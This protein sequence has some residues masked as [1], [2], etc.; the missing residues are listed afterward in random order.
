MP[1]IFRGSAMSSSASPSRQQWKI[2]VSAAIAW[3]GFCSLQ[4][5]TASVRI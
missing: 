5:Y 1:S 4:Y 2:I 3:I